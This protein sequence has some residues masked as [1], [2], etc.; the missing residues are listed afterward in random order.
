MTSDEITQAAAQKCADLANE[1]MGIPDFWEAA[2][3]IKPTYPLGVAFR[4]FVEHID[5]RDR[6]VLALLDDGCAKGEWVQIFRCRDLLRADLLPEPTLY[7]QFFAEIESITPDE[8][9]G[10]RLFADW[11]AKRGVEVKPKEER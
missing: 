6:E 10:A 9:A 5:A 1:A 4:H 11:I 7:E 3:I 2:D 8:A